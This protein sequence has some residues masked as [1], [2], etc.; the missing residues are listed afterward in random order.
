MLSEPTDP[1]VWQ[2]LAHLE[3][4]NDFKTVV[5]WLAVE[6]EKQRCHNDI[7]VIEVSLRMGQGC[8]QTLDKLLYIARTARETVG[9]IKERESANSP[10]ARTA[11]SF[12]RTV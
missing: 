4:V 7:E 8:A 10:M 2:A 12:A 11:H 3:H 9:Q 1:S 5:D 6:L